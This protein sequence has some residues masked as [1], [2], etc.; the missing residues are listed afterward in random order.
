[1]TRTICNKKQGYKVVNPPNMV[2]PRSGG[3]LVSSQF[4]WQFLLSVHGS[5]MRLLHWNFCDRL[6]PC[7][8]RR[9]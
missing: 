3:V 8:H 9:L 5:R 2:W 6:K 1:L 7:P 4:F